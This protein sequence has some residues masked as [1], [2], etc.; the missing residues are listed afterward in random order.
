MDLWSLLRLTFAAL[1]IATAAGQILR[2]FAYSAKA[3][4]T[5]ADVNLRLV[6]WWVLCGVFGL[7]LA[8]GETPAIA[9][10]AILSWL[11]FAE[12]A[13]VMELN[14]DWIALPFTAV[15]YALVWNGHNYGMTILILACAF[16][17]LPVLTWGL[18]ICAYC[19]SYAPALL[20]LEIPGYTGRNATLLFYFLVVVQSSDVLQYCWGKLF[21]RHR[22][23][24][25]ISP[26]KTWE[27]LIGGVLT[28]TLLGTALY[29]A[30]PFQPWQ[31]AAICAAITLLGVAGGLA[32]SAI[33]RARGVKDFGTL[34][35]GHGGVLDRLDSIC[36]SAPVFFFVVR[37]FYV[38]R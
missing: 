27:G 5:A 34:V 37:Y 2:R 14:A 32:M 25:R 3:V 21:G 7:A 22:L 12:Y 6:S 28:S 31:A 9:L 29:R 18:L 16:L 33:K 8:L 1:L 19:V 17:F 38:L 11:A 20:T 24:P 30:T 26:N 23:A 35:V 15:Q 36:L 4:A 13:S 10:F